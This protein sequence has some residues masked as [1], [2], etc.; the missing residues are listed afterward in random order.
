[1]QFARKNILDMESLSVDEINMILDTADRMKEISQRPVK[2]V[3]T[4][5]GKTVVL[6]FYE[7]STRTRA[8]F[9]IAAKRLSADSLSLSAGSSS[10]VKGESL[11]DTAR[12]LE[13]M[14][15]DVIVIRH[16]SA[17]A[18]HLL[19][20]TVNAAIINA[21]DGMH[22]HPTQALLDLMTVRENKGKITGLRIAI[23]GDIA[24]SRVARS[25]CIGFK[26]MGAEVVLAGPPTMIPKGI[27]SLGVSV[28]YHIDDAI[29]D[30]DIIMMLRIQ[31]ERQKHFLFST[32]REYSKVY[33]LTKERLK[34][35]RD[36]VLIMHPGPINRGVE[37]ASDVADGPYSLILDQVTNGVAVRMA[38]L[39]LVAGGIRD[40][41]AD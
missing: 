11:I 7:P 25:N 15:P 39:Y 10:M 12:N 32:E 41:D 36:D 21:G 13:A 8:S 37:I 22:A 17:G 16:P 26:K 19:A 9:D 2:K 35:A 38:L 24:H 20:R 29:G 30:A 31:K 23:I 28:T 5:R 14:N 6:F 34:N 3:P 18:P 33:G 4:L 27:E 1:M 40:A